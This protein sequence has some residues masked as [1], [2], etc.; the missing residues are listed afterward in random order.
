MFSDEGFDGLVMLN[1]L[2]H[3]K[4]I[5]PGVYGVGSA[6]SVCSARGQVNS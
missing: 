3:L 2:D 6:S 4:V 1:R 5:G